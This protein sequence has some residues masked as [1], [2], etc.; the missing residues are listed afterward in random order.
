MRALIGHG[1]LQLSVEKETLETIVF[2]DVID[3]LFSSE[4]HENKTLV[5]RY[6]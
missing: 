5:K 6:L 3:Q 4:G 2:D 1:H